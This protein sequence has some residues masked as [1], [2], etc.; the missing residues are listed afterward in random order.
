MCDV[1]ILT[2]L[3][4]ID[5]V[6]RLLPIGGEYVDTQDCVYSYVNILI[7]KLGVYTLGVII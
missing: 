3:I 2:C 1:T 7:C 5:G 4:S 6:V